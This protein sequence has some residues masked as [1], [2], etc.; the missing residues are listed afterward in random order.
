[1]VED[2]LHLMTHS[3]R[4]IIFCIFFIRDTFLIGFTVY[5]IFRDFWKMATKNMQDPMF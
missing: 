2:T 1:M 5:E 4:E 3:I